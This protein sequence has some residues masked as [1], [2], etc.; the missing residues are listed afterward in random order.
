MAIQMILCVETKKTADTDS[1]YIYETIKRW[2][3]IDNT[4]KLN[5]VY[6]NTKSKYNS[7]SVMRDIAK[8]TKDYI[9]GET[10]VI[11]FIDTDQYE[12]NV[13]HAREFDEISRFCQVN[14][15]ELVWFCHDVEEVFWGH[16]VS[17]SKK[18]K[19]AESFRR[20]RKIEEL[21]IAKLSCDAK[22]TCSS[23]II[24]VLDMYL[25]RK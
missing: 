20:K 11:Y 17:D 16:K 18:V 5:K 23:N 9:L 12:I 6:M 21:Q 25:A 1:V 15:Y 22:K 10:R 13:D 24:K 19:E 8:K 2:Y 7:K 4:V 14:G 3:K